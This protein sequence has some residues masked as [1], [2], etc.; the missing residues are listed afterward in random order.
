MNTKEVIEKIK[1]TFSELV[2]VEKQNFMEATLKDGTAVQVTELAVGGIVSINGTPA[3]TGEHEL[4]D[5][6]IL[7]VGDNG[8]ITE[9]KMPA[10]APEETAPAQED[11]GVKFSAFETATNEKFASYES[12][13]AAYEQRFAA[14]ETKLEAATKV[15]NDLI[16]LTQKLAETPT[17]TPD[18]VVKAGNNFHSD[19]KEKSFNYDLLFS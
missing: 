16:T 9:I 5:G 2:N 4:T 8:A 19:K 14:Y 17:G 15:I 13:F 1:Q 6:T 18:E 10:A 12:K 11:M 3:P 7:V